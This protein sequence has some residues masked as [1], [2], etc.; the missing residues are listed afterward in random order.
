MNNVVYLLGAGF[1]AP[2]GLPVMSNFLSVSKDLHF[3]N[4]TQ[5]SHFEKVFKLIG[6][7]AVAKNLYQAN[8]WNIEEILSILEM[9]ESLGETNPKKEFLRYISDVVS[10]C[11]PSKPLPH[12]LHTMQAFDFLFDDYQWN[13]YGIFFAS[14]LRLTFKLKDRTAMGGS[15]HDRFA[16]RHNSNM[17]YSLVSLNYDEVCERVV[18]AFRLHYMDKQNAAAFTLV[19]DFSDTNAVS[20]CALPLAKL[21]GTVGSTI[22][23]PTWNKN[24][25]PDLLNVWKAAHQLLGRANHLRILGYSLPESDAYLRY[26][27]KSAAIDSQHLKSIDV[28]CLDPDDSV[29]KRYQEFI[30]FPRLRFANK[31]MESY[32][33]FSPNKIDVRTSSGEYQYDTLEDHHDAFMSDYNSL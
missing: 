21:H 30:T 9:R 31:D 8:L 3:E 6:E 18:D 14:L 32:L 29:K 22:I 28:I 25:H 7:M 11:T 1:S 20:Q 33:G 27:L 16:I 12:D 17:Q 2:L 15:T 4:P 24:L 23:P 5:F 19:T 10:A 26:L 13:S